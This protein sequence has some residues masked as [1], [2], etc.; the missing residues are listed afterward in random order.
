VKNLKKPTMKYFIKFNDL[1]FEISKSIAEILK[2]AFN[3]FTL[4]TQD[5]KQTLTFSN[6][7]LSYF[8]VV[9]TTS[10]THFYVLIF[11]KKHRINKNFYTFLTQDFTEKSG[12]LEKSRTK[13]VRSPIVLDKFY[14]K[15]SV[16]Q[17]C[18]SAFIENVKIEENDLIL[19]PSA[20][21]GSFIQPMKAIKCNKIFLD[22]A[23]ENNQIIQTNFLY[24]KPPAV[25][26][27]IHLIGNPPFGRQSS[28]CHKFIKHGA[29]FAETIGFVLPGSFN[30]A[31]NRNK[32]PLNFQLI[33]SKDLGKNSCYDTHV[34]CVFQI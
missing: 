25:N 28:L 31:G 17:Q 6:S 9:K 1:T 2:K 30:K 33:F 11:N 21:N 10:Q 18:V 29:T 3:N 24:W 23:P 7:I 15:P 4:E 27:K 32:I 12:T 20:G 34:N 14:T 22:I 5:K 8:Q 19:E 13:T 26:G 16:A